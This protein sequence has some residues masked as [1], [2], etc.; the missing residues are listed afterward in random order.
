[1]KGLFHLVEANEGF[2]GGESSMILFK[3][4]AGGPYADEEG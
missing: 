1:M 4:I 3:P 2:N